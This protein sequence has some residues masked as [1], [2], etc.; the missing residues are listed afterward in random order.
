MRTIILSCCI[1]LCL[2][3]GTVSVAND[4]PVYELESVS[5]QIGS[6]CKFQS[7]SAGLLKVNKGYAWFLTAG[8]VL[9]KSPNIHIGNN[10]YPVTKMQEWPTRSLMRDSVILLRTTIP[11]PESGGHKTYYLDPEGRAPRIGDKVW[12]IG[13]PK[14]KFKYLNSIITTIRTDQF[15]TRHHLTSGSSGGVVV[16]QDSSTLAGIIHGYSMISGEGIAT[17]SDLIVEGLRR[18]K[19]AY[20]LPSTATEVPELTEEPPAEVVAPDPQPPTEEVEGPAVDIEQWKARQADALKKALE[21]ARKVQDD[22]LRQYREEDTQQKDQI[23]REILRVVEGHV[24]PI[25]KEHQD[26]LDALNNKNDSSDGV[27][28]PVWDPDPPASNFPIPWKTLFGVLGIAV[29][30]G[31]LGW[32]ALS[33]GSRL[34]RTKGDPKAAQP[35]P[36]FQRDMAEAE[37]IIDL[38]QQEQREPVFDSLLGILFEDEYTAKPDQSLEEAH[39]AIY[40]RF[41][42]IAPVSVK[43]TEE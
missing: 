27:D 31:A 41:N 43:T 19:Y 17:R 1:Q 14:G 6:L 3:L 33:A 24:T 40:R 11:I 36:L 2:L 29:P 23:I 16:F 18:G 28:A 22:S 25:L 42:K 38:R 20:L 34:L 21:D 4:Y 9:A 39:A 5:C 12:L 13:Y 26:K 7:G 35:A 15:A 10:K 30:G 32:L 8:H 37:Q